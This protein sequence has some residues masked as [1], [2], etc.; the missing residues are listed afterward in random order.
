MPL[1]FSDDFCT[2]CESIAWIWHEGNDSIRCH[3]IAI[4]AVLDVDLLEIH[5]ISLV[6]WNIYTITLSRTVLAV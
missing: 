6:H 5:A 1:E 4:I 2:A 3:P